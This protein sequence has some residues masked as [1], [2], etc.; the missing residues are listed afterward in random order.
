MVVVEGGYTGWEEARQVTTTWRTLTAIYRDLF[1]RPFRL[2]AARETRDRR[3]RLL[4]LVAPELV[5]LPWPLH[6]C[7]LELLP[8]MLAQYHVWHRRQGHDRAPDGG[9]RCC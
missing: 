2:A 8:E 3:D 7:A 9:W 1:L 5:G 6:P 4:L